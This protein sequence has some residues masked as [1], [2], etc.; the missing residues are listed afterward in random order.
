MTLERR[1]FDK[2]IK[3]LMKKVS[4]RALER[5]IGLSE[6]YLS[7]IKCGRSEPS[8]ILV[9]TLIMLDKNLKKG[10]TDLRKLWTGVQREAL[11]S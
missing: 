8:P 9:S 6:G 11:A 10:L 3:R 7:K 5:H 1:L 2:L 4:L